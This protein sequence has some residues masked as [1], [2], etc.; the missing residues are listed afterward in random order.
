MLR[1]LA[2]GQGLERSAEWLNRF[3]RPRV[4]SACSL[5]LVIY[6]TNHIL[7]AAAPATYLF[8]PA[9]SKATRA[10]IHGG[11]PPGLAPLAA[12][13]GVLRRPCAGAGLRGARKRP[14]A[15]RLRGAAPRCIWQRRRQLPTPPAAG[16][17]PCTPTDTLS[18]DPTS[19]PHRASYQ[20]IISCTS[21]CMYG[22]EALDGSTRSMS[23]RS[24]WWPFAGI[25]AK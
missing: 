7:C 24:T 15:G 6:R 20:N 10:C 4:Y 13:A 9:G 8:L 1:R 19:C 22:Q 11:V 16:S 3:S 23:R 18:A 2:P 12:A 14:Q 25:L 17:E 21:G 5:Q